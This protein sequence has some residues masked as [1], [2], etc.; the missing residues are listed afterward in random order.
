LEELKSVINQPVYR[1]TLA[2]DLKRR[3]GRGHGCFQVSPSFWDSETWELDTSRVT[4]ESFLS[5]AVWHGVVP[6]VRARAEWGGLIPWPISGQYEERWPLLLDALA[7]DVPEPTMVE[8]LL[9]LDADPN[10]K[11]SKIDSQTCWYCE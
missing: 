1:M 7:G 5:L 2:K 11:I 10:F 6:Y 8:C 4:D 9:D 3:R